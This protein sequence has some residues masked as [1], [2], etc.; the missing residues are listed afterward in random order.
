MSRFLALILVAALVPAPLLAGQPSAKRQGC[1]IAK[2]QP[3]RNVQRAEPCR[4]APPVP[5]VI[6]PTPTF[7]AQA[8][9]PGGYSSLLF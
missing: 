7:L 6:D 9:V 4:R 2:N 3:Q 8:T 5:P 1:Q